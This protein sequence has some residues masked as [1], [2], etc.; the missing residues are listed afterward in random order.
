MFRKSLSVVLAWTLVVGTG[1]GFAVGLESGSMMPVPSVLSQV[2]VTTETELLEALENPE[3]TSIVLA[4]DIVSGRG[5]TVEH[6]VSIAGAGHSITAVMP[7]LGGTAPP[8]FNVTSVIEILGTTGVSIGDIV[9][10]GGRSCAVFLA[11]GSAALFGSV[12]VSGNGGYGIEMYSSSLDVTGATLVNS[13][14]APDSPTIYSFAGTVTG[15][16]GYQ[17]IEETGAVGYYLTGPEDE[18][19]G[20]RFDTPA[21]IALKAFP[22]G[23]GTVILATGNHWADALSGSALAGVLDAPILLVDVGA[24]L[25]DP[26]ARALETLAPIR[27]I[28]L[29]GPLAVDVGLESSLRATGYSVERI[30]GETRYDTSDAVA[31][32]VIS[33][34]A[35]RGTPWDGTALF[36][37]GEFYADALAASPLAAARG[38]P[39]FLVDPSAGELSPEA[40]RLLPRIKNAVILGGD[41]AVP[42]RFESTFA[43]ATLVRVGG[44]TWADT[45]AQIA[46]YEVDRCGMSWGNV[47]IATGDLPYDALAGGVLQA[48]RG[49]V[50]LLTSS[51]SLSPAAREAIAENR[52]AIESVTYFGGELAVS[53]AVRDAVAAELAR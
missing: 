4:A 38:W 47:A 33:G 6:P 37:T 36:T 3:I 40:R 17:L 24:V 30:W 18:Y 48:K 9:L 32:R 11:S 5:F 26:T 34:N 31:A 16:S 22:D 49:S 28:I 42:G 2:W 43:K 8:D 7:D 50:M 1:A 41:L 29:G 10:R 23:A 21:T 45:A 44:P 19:S 14:E 20:S 39:V 35:R 46:R 15:F 12:D 13:T 25:P 51:T 52:D 53:R 27:V